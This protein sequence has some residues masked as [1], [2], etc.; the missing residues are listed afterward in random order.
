MVPGPEFR[1]IGFKRKDGKEVEMKT[2]CKKC[3]GTNT[4]WRE[5]HPDTGMDEV[6][7]VCKDC[8]PKI[9]TLPLWFRVR[10]KL[11]IKWKYSVG[12]Y[13][14]RVLFKLA[15]LSTGQTYGYCTWCGRQPGFA[16]S[17]SRKGL[18]CADCQDY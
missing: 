5:E 9:H 15:R 16:S 1:K 2:A 6:V 4:Y 18:R 17:Y 10:E 14:V 7:L 11:S 13:I 8:Q 3:G 12:G